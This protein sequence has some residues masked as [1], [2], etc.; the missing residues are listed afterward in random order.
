[1]KDRGDGDRRGADPKR[2]IRKGRGVCEW[3]RCR[4]RKGTFT[5]VTMLAG[6][7]GILASVWSRQVWQVVAQA[8]CGTKRQPNSP[9]FGKVRHEARRDEGL[10][11]KQRDDNMPDPGHLI[12]GTGAGMVGDGHPSRLP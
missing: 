11:Q 8:P 6:R 12:A 2:V 10:Q 7:A 4:D 9:L 1:M 3:R 5:L